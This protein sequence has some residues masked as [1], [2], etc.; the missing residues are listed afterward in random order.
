MATI[1]TT[2]TTKLTAGDAATIVALALKRVTNKAGQPRARI[3]MTYKTFRRLTGR[4][5]GGASFVTGFTDELM[6]L[7]WLMVRMPS[8]YGFVSA[9]SLSDW[10]LAKSDR[11]AEELKR[12]EEGFSAEALESARQELK[13]SRDIVASPNNSNGAAPRRREKAAASASGK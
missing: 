1:S 7:G 2:G 9:A 4:R 12:V 6:K 8:A 5:I 13:G 3:R 11:I 10:R